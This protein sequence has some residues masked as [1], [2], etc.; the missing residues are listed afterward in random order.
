MSSAT[1]TT[2]LTWE[3]FLELPDEPRY[4][5][6]EL[7]DGEL[8]LVNPPSWLHQQVVG[9]LVALIWTWI[10]AEPGRGTVTMDP[11]VRITGIRGYLPDVAWY[12]DGRSRPAPGNPYLTGPPDLAVEVLSPSTRAFDVVRKRADYARVGVGELWLVDPENPS[13]LV[14]RPPA[15]PTE[16][17][18]FVVVEELGRDGALTSPLLPGLSIPVGE[19]V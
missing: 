13:A 19:L 16:P 7:V 6:A 4:R 12:R 14:M 2:G 8:I 17:A 1:A 3:E 5:H 11:P 15:Q 9:A 10:R 18:E